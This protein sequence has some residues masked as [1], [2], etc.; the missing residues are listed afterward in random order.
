MKRDIAETPALAEKIEPNTYF[1]IT[2]PYGY[3]GFIWDGE[4]DWT[5]LNA[6][7]TEYCRS[8]MIVSE[9]VRFHP[10]LRNAEGAEAMYEVIQRGTTVAMDLSSPET[11]WDGFTSQNRKNIRKAQNSGARI[12]R[13]ST[14]DKIYCFAEMYRETMSRVN[15]DDYYYFDNAFFDSF[16]TGFGD[17]HCIFY[18]V[19]EN[20]IVAMSI[21]IFTNR[22]MHNFLSCSLDEVKRYALKNILYYE[23]ALW[24]HKMGLKTSHLGGG[25]GGRQDGLYNFKKAFNRHHDYPYYTGQRIYDDVTYQKLLEL[26]RGDGMDVREGFFPEYRG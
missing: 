14:G 6:E 9:F 15:A 19:L 26:R 12:E 22:Q 10:V 4:P 3:G 7:F 13:S 5:G 25:V 18:A 17:N 16:A 23:A 21:I 11:I 1:D 20:K 24:G 8:E 2:T